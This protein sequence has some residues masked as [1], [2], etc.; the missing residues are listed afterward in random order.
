MHKNDAKLLLSRLVEIT[1]KGKDKN[2][3]HI[4]PFCNSGT[5]KHKT[6]AFNIYDKTKFHCFNCNTSGDIFTYAGKLCESD[7]FKDQ[8][9]YIEKTLKIKI[10][11]D[12]N[13]QDNDTETL[14]NNAYL[15]DSLDFNITEVKD[16]DFTDFFKYAHENINKC[17]YWKKRGLSKETIDKFNIGYIENWSNNKSNITSPRLIIPTSNTSYLARDTRDNL[18]LDQQNY[19]KQKVGKSCI[20]NV[21]ALYQDQNFVFIVEGEIDALSVIEVGFNAC[22]LGSTSNTNA[23]INQ[24]K[25]KATNNT[26]ILALDCD[27]AGQKATD[28]LSKKLQELKIDFY[29]FNPYG[30]YKD[31]NECLVK[32]KDLFI[33]NLSQAIQ[34]KEDLEKTNQELYLQYS[35][36]NALKRLQKYI[37]DEKSIISTGFK[38]LDV[39]L[40]GGLYA[41]LYT[42]GAISSLGKTTLTL[43]IADQVA[44]QNN[45]VLIFSLEMATNELIAKSISR[46]SYLNVLE[47]KQK[48]NYAKTA[49]A[50]LN[51]TLNYSSEE[52]AIISDCF[53]TY[54]KFANNIFIREGVFNLSVKDVRLMIE[55]HIRYRNKKPFVIIDYLQILAPINDRA[56]DKQKVDENISELKR[57]SRDFN[58]P[59][60]II[61]SLNRTSYTNKIDLNSFK[62]SGSIEYSSDVVLGLE[63]ACMEQTS[64]KDT[65]KVSAKIQ[66]AKKETIRNIQLVV[67]KN[68]FG[69]VGSKIDFSYFTLFNYFKEIDKSNTVV[70]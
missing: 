48:E 25:D 2:N 52:R 60:F 20:F 39:A 9:A 17:D 59:I 1:S 70:V 56:T 32:D 66:E 46:L 49:R 22:A 4:C 13:N 41:G 27:Q 44:M 45:D 67:L 36:T 21:A 37:A 18:S 62:E 53:Y 15:S 28:I 29:I 61:S 7:N 43:Q 55:D 26:L 40:E 68:R 50:I 58:I 51:G 54:E 57:I 34:Y 65:S 6:S 64:Q 19:S 63:F 30:A 12:Y 14:I 33:K 5:G 69:K 8:I 35:G 47:K 10:D 3:K 31:A 24:L 42:L 16:Q 23:L 38:Q 11:N